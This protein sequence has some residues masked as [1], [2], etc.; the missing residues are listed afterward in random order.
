ML[1][2]RLYLTISVITLLLMGLLSNGDFSVSE[3]LKLPDKAERSLAIQLP[4]AAAGLREGVFFCECLPA[5]L[6]RRLQRRIDIDPKAIAGE[7]RQFN[8]RF[9]G[10][11]GGAMLVLLPSFALWL[12]LAYLNRR[13]RYTVHLVFALQLHAFWFLALALL[14]WQ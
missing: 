11:L 1:P 10:N 8:E 14:G 2:L 7:V 9:L 3:P 5:V 4:G 6:C 13:L 12:K